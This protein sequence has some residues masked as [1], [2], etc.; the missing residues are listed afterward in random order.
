A[1]YFEIAAAGFTNAGVSS[2]LSITQYP[3]YYISQEFLGS[4]FSLI[5]FIFTMNS[6]IGSAIAAY[7]A[8]SRLTYTMVKKNMLLSII[9]VAIF[10][11]FFNS[12]AAITGNYNGIYNITTEASLTTLFSSHLIIS[13]VYP[14]FVMK[15]RLGNFK[16]NM[17]LAIASVILMGYGIYS[18]LISGQTLVGILA[19][20]A[21]IIIGII[22][23]LITKRHI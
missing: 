9:I 2:L 4:T 17:G 10:F 6:L 15:N 11:L 21:G 18:N 22:Q 8:L 19:I 16:L 20:I 7:V 13:A 5:F 23:H 14:R 3:G 12:L 1:S